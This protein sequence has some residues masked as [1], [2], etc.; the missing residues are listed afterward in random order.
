MRAA[1]GARLANVQRAKTAPAHNQVRAYFQLD[2]SLGDVNG[3]GTVS[4][5]DVTLLVNRILGLPDDGLVVKNADL[6]GDGMMSVADV[7]LLVNV[8][9]NISNQ[10]SVV[11]KGAEGI[12]F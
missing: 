2:P 10:F 11:V 8:I 6:N 3:D 5:T 1:R 4:V 12:T 7:T 9:L